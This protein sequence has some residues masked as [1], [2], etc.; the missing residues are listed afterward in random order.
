MYMG[1]PE[2]TYIYMCI[3]IYIYT[4]KKGEIEIKLSVEKIYNIYYI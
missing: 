4:E 1:F 3:Y 2:N